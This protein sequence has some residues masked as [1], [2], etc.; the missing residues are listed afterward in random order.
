VQHRII[1]V[2]DHPLANGSEA[3]LE[4][5]AGGSITFD[6]E[7]AEQASALRKIFKYDNVKQLEAC[8]TKRGFVA[9][10]FL[11]CK[12]TLSV[13][14]RRLMVTYIWFKSLESAST[15]CGKVF[16]STSEILCVVSNKLGHGGNIKWSK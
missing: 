7:L 16:N 15:P 14:F 11:T 3:P 5:A 12:L 9:K 13:P 4:L 10:T 6:C 8:N 2:A 1:S